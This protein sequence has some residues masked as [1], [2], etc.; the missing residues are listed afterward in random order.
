[1]G[2]EGKKGQKVECLGLG[3]LSSCCCCDDWELAT[4]RCVEDFM[5]QQPIVRPSSPTNA[6]VPPLCAAGGS[7]Y[8]IIGILDVMQ[9][10]KPEIQTVAM[11][12]CYS[13]SSLI[14]AAGT[15]GRRYSMKNTRIMM[16]QPM[17][18]S[19]G[20]WWEISKTVEELNA[21][22]QLISRFYMKYTGMDQDTVEMNTCRDYFM[23]P[24]Q[25]QQVEIF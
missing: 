14:L 17:G 18:G 25:A 6:L 21:L 12:A 19:A 8:S 1:M 16:T 13:Y 10:I 9:S 20:S 2:G 24:E 3:A 5:H 7:P 11:G 4:S 22:Y 15:R 23:T